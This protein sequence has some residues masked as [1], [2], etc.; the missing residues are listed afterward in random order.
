MK[1]YFITGGEGFIG[2][3]ICKELLKDPENRIVTYD[4]QKHYI[5]LDQSYW[6]FYQDYRIKSLDND[7]VE[8]VRGDTTDRGLLKEKLEE[9]SLM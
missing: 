7:N 3:H 5:P 8:R 1:T 6:T 2:Y 9:Y 4:A